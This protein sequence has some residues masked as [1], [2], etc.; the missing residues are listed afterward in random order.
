LG[1]HVGTDLKEGKITL[2]FIHALKSVSEKE[3]GSAARIVKKNTITQ[4]D[5]EWVS[6]LIEK[7]DGIGYTSAATEKY[8][9]DAKKHLDQFPASRYKDGLLSL[10]NSMLRREK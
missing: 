8:L 5:F 2:P 4:K 7:Y 3:K 9:T 6:R 10:A 1:K